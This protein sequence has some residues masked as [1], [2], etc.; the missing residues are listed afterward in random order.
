MIGEL[1]RDARQLAVAATGQ[2]TAGSIARV[3]LGTDSYRITFLQRIRNAAR[4]AHIPLVNHLLRM[5]QTALFGIEID[6]DVTLGDG[7]Y[8]VHPLGIVIGGDSRIGAR[9]RFYGSNTVGTVRDDGYPT[10]EEDVRVGAGA[11]IL[12]PIRIGA[13]AQ[14]GANAVVMVDVPADGVAVGVPAR[15]LRPRAQREADGAAAEPR[16]PPPA[17]LSH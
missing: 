1:I 8:L 3:V 15:V 13:R 14:I 16:D 12:G 6:R 17:P 4:T 5:V 10:I 11:R 7:V 9:V 2:A